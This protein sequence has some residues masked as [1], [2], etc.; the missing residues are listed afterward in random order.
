MAE[1]RGRARA[2]AAA[3]GS[4]PAAAG[5]VQRPEARPAL[6]LEELLDLLVRGG[7]LAEAS[8]ADVLARATTLRSRVLKERVGSVRSQAAAR[9]D[10][11]PA[12]IVAAAN[13]PHPRKSHRRLDEDAIAEALA[14][15]S[16]AAYP[17]IE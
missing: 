8:R 2:G 6:G 4:R 9:Y 7:D 13:L 3:G 16:G 14:K 15:A 5:R 12:E 17:K 11:S 1:E 10:V